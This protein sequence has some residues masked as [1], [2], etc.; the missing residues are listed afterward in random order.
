MRVVDGYRDTVNNKIEAFK[1]EIHHARYNYENECQGLMEGFAEARAA[2][3][4][5]EA[6]GEIFESRENN[7]ETRLDNECYLHAEHIR[8]KFVRTLAGIHKKYQRDLGM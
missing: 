1:N 6:L 2:S 7:L 8:V 5:A 3:L 4:E